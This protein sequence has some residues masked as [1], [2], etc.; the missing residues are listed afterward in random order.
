M[1]E[2]SWKNWAESKNVFLVGG[3]GGVGKTTLAAVLGIQLARAGYKT[4]VL[5]VDPAKRLAQALGFNEGFKSE[6]Q[7][8]GLPPGTT[9]S[10]HASMLDAQRYFDKLIDKFA[11]DSAQKERI[12]ANPLY[13]GM[14]DGLSGTQE[15][16]AMERLLEFSTDTRFDK[17]VVDTPPTQNAVDLLSAPQRMADFMDNSVLKWFQGPKPLYFQF[18]RQGTRLAMKLIQKIFGAEFLEKFSKFMDDLEGMQ[19]GFRSRNLEVL[20]LLRSARTAFL[21]VTYPSEARYVES[22]SF[23]K[24]LKENRIEL[25]G[26]ILNRLEPFC[27]SEE[28]IAASISEPERQAFL[29]LFRYLHSLYAQQQHWV[30][31]F[32]EAAGTVPSLCLER[33]EGE[34]HDVSTLSQLG[35]LL[36][37]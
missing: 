13:R 28:N 7:P 3:P 9:G 2:G 8:V 10:L 31:K 12:L 36:L 22:V 16:A 23:L 35:D 30:S 32:R 11:R 14:V 25:A 20:E 18:F 37:K 34:I 29:D 6:L 21:L 4:L 1:A 24:T 15:Y 27:P 17:V 26:L 19:A 5:T 33:Q